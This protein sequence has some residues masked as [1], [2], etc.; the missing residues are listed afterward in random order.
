MNKQELIDMVVDLKRGLIGD[1]N[2]Y[3]NVVLYDSGLFYLVTEEYAKATSGT[4]ICN[5]DEYKHRARELGWIKGYK[6]GV[7]YPT[8][9]K[10]PDL[11]DDT[12]VE[13]KVLCYDKWGCV[14]ALGDIEY[15]GSPSNALHPVAFRIVDERYKP[16][17]KSAPEQA[18]YVR[19]DFPPIGTECQL[20]PHWHNVEIIAYHEGA[21]VYYDKHDMKYDRCPYPN[22][23]RRIK[24]D[25]EILIEN[26]SVVIHRL[27]IEHGKMSSFELAE[28]LYNE[29]LLKTK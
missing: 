6:W 11:P 17:S 28:R 8:N 27:E 1:G 25:R 5:I 16:K 15:W 22:H 9:S 21:A 12:L 7:E 19:N 3:A 4:V 2:E 13:I 10:K 23:F 20:K 26:A 24:T 14:L 29:G 18:W